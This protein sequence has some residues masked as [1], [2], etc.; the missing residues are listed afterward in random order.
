MARPASASYQVMKFARRHKLLLSA[1]AAIFAVLLSGVIVSTREAIHARQAEQTAQAVSD[2]LRKDLLAQASVAYQSGEIG[3]LDPD[4]KVRTALDLAANQLTGKFEKQPDIEVAIRDTIADTYI[5]L[6]R[7]ADARKQWER[8]LEIRRHLLGPEHPDTL[9]TMRGV[10]MAS[11]QEGNFAQ[12]E[13]LWRR[14][15]EVHRRVLGPEHLDTTDCMYEL[16]ILYDCQ[17]KYA[18]GQPL[19]TQVAEIRRRVLGPDRMGTLNAMNEVA[20]EY[21]GLGQYAKAEAILDQ[22]VEISRRRYG[23][24]STDTVAFMD[25]LATAY[26]AD[27]KY[28]QAGALFDQI[29]RSG[30]GVVWRRIHAFRSLALSIRIPT[31]GQVQIGG[32]LCRAGVGS[33]AAPPC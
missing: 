19:A 3:K 27:G 25:S 13:V 18:Q 26:W 24:K 15:L 23:P 20:A 10:A 12:A 14:A 2:F 7:P 33:G 17:R 6:G 28:A 8:V 1:T 29:L 9:A 5:Q 16:A 30:K 21:C 4:L 11:Q 31:R 32:R 22:V